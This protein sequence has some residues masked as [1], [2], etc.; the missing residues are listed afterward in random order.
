M[1]VLLKNNGM[2]LVMMIVGDFNKISKLII[3]NWFKVLNKNLI[4]IVFGELKLKVVV[5]LIFGIVFGKIVFEIFWK[6]W[7]SLLMKVWI[8]NCKIVRYI[9]KFKEVV[10]M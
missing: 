8:F 2:K 7:V 5:I 1:I 10:I 9:V 6:D 3:K 4:V